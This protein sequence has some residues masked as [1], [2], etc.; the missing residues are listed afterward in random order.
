MR[1][2][3]FREYSEAA[4]L[5]RMD[6]TQCGKSTVEEI[7][8]RFDGEVERFCNLETGQQATIDAP[9]VLEL[10]AQCAATH[11]RAGDRLLDLGC[12]AGNFTLRVMQ[13]AGSMEC[14]MVDLS[15]PMLERARERLQ[16]AGA[17]SVTTL[18][19]DFRNL[20]LPENSVDCILAG[21]TL[22]HLRGDDDW[23]RVFRSLHRFLKPGGRLYVADLVVFDDPALQTLMWGRYG[24]FLASFG[25]E[26][27]RDKVFAYIEKEDTPRSLAFQL[28][29]AHELGFSSSEVLHR[30]SVFA[31]YYALK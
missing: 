23:R 24:N 1:E 21:A 27:Y 19:A 15:R 25:G 4:M 22:H 10:V 2:T 7:R 18:Q 12:G 16:A 13:E 29:L 28:E 14:V 17:Q 11:L 3:Q 6:T 26:T 31:C 30:N 20:D 9:L 8:A 5:A